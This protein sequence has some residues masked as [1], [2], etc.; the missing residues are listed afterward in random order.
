M[1]SIG[2]EDGKDGTS[3]VLTQLVSRVDE[4]MSRMEKLMRENEKLKEDMQQLVAN[5]QQTQQSKQSSDPLTGGTMEQKA[6]ESVLPA[7]KTPSPPSTPP[8]AG[9]RKNISLNDAD[10]LS[11]RIIEASRSLATAEL[12]SYGDQ[13]VLDNQRARYFMSNL[14]K[15]NLEGVR[16]EV[17][18]NPELKNMRT[19]NQQGRRGFTALHHAAHM[20]NAEMCRF[21]VQELGF[22]PYATDLNGRTALHIAA[23]ELKKDATVALME[24]MDNG[25]VLGEAAPV[26]ASGTTPAGHSALSKVGTPAD[27]AKMIK[28]LHKLGDQSISPLARTKNRKQRFRS[29]LSTATVRRPNREAGMAPVL[30]YGHA[31]L[32]GYRVQME[33]A[34]Y[35][36]PNVIPGVS[37]FVVFDGHGGRAS[38]DFAAKHIEDVFKARAEAISASSSPRSNPEALA[39]ILQE[40]LQELDKQLLDKFIFTSSDGK[41]KILNTS[42]STATIAAITDTHIVLA[43]VGD[44]RSI[45]FEDSK[46]LAS[47]RDHCYSNSVDTEF[48][49]SERER[50]EAAGGMVIQKGEEPNL[51]FSIC[52]DQDDDSTQL[53][54]TRALGDVEY[55]NKEQPVI[56]SVPET[57]IIPRNVDKEQFV[58]LAC[59][60]VWDVKS[61]ED[62]VKAVEGAIA[63]PDTTDLDG[64]AEMV[65]VDCL[66][67]NDNISIVIVQLPKRDQDPSRPSE[68]VDLTSVFDKMNIQEEE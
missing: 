34:V 63:Q 25:N 57:F 27:R 30:K 61:N 43:N 19:L 17:M 67:S 50:I 33:D 36:A 13:P 4:L 37:M 60:G 39:T 14:M 31:S 6:V 7:P 22:D 32:P 54:M 64:A 58:V 41:Q 46:V 44:S 21:L 53:A 66:S 29:R 8:A 3:K 10:P 65:A 68:A 26:D 52:P 45:V 28:M 9:Q 18:M 35:L 20:G 62:T 24:L 47:T 48:W 12:M 2:A 11:E 55:K 51:R 5:Q 42:G 38:A 1:A 56:S 15:G 40:T 16:R 23:G 59:D 49:Q